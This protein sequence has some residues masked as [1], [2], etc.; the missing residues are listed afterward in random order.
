MISVPPSHELSSYYQSY[1]KYISADADLLSLI[2]EQAL[3]TQHFLAT[4]PADKESFVYAPGKWRLKE[5][6]GHICDAER[7]LSYRA[8]RI[9]RNDKTPLAGFEENLYT[10][11]SNYQS[12][13]LRNIA[14]EFATVRQASISLFSN[15]SDEMFDRRGFANDSDVSVRAIC[16]FIA[17]HER[18]HLQVIKDRYLNLT[19]K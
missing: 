15:M 19:S 1:L 12:R 2:K 18:H 7:I 9:S 5:V 10:P 6:V 3:S 8:L 17:G 4:I 11:N 13:S 16:F 14:E